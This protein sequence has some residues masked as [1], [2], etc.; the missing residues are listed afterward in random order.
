[1]LAESVLFLICY[2]LYCAAEEPPQR[3]ERDSDAGTAVGAMSG[4]HD[5][6]LLSDEAGPVCQPQTVPG[7]CRKNRIDRP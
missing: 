6:H 1:M 2:V 4:G 7:C 3:D 5:E